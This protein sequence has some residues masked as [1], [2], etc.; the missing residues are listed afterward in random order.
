LTFVIDR[1]KL[2]DR[3]KPSSF[4]MNISFALHKV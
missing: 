1:S 2:V 4:L 3:P